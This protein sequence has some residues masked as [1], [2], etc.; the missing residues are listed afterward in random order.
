MA[1]TP[2][3]DQ[4]AG[5]RPIAFVLDNVGAIST[6]VTLQIRP[7]DLTRTEPSRVA[8]HQTLGRDVSGWV[9]NF[10]EGL[11][12]VTISGHT[13]WRTASGSHMDGVAAFQALNNL[14]AHD[15]HTAKQQAINAGIDPALVKLIF[16]DMLDGFTWNVVPQTFQLKRN[17]SRPLLMQYNIVLQAVST[18]VDNPLMLL[19]ISGNLSAGLESLGRV[20]SFL[21]KVKSKV[22]GWV[23]KALGFV[24][25]VLSPIA[26]T[27][28]QFTSMAHKV[29]N[30]VKGVV[31]SVKGVVG[32]AAGKLVG[33]ADSISQV[34]RNLFRT[35]SSIRNLPSDL[36]ASLSEV[37]GAFN[38][39]ACLFKNALKPQKSY[40]NYT[41]LYGASNCSSTVGGRPH[42]QY[43]DVNPFGLMQ[44]EKG[45]VEM[46]SQ[47]LSS[48]TALGR[49]DPVLAP[50]PYPEVQRHLT[51][52]VGG[53]AVTG[54]SA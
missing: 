34:G 54:A 12:S 7:E 52:I 21:G 39:A 37:A 31:N 51:N 14:V 6:P 24:N 2:P 27:V 48:T 47:A 5:V 36:K 46:N 9:D 20:T 18:N 38:E 10:G 35:I 43:A 49:M 53:T 26:K 28:K 40:E 30:T 3:T 4:R 17:K 15:F 25:S 13:G 11:P 19:P 50:M 22:E 45:P 33:I 42:S 8:I 1:I 23:S 44:P 16:V 32:A 29:L 41:G